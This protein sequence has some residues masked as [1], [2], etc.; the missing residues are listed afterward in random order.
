MAT[1]VIDRIFDTPTSTSTST[2][3]PDSDWKSLMN[4]LPHQ[5]KRGDEALGFDGTPIPGAHFVKRIVV[6]VKAIYKGPNPARL[7]DRTEAEAAAK[8]ETSLGE[9]GFVPKECREGIIIERIPD[10][11]RLNKK[12]PKF[13]YEFTLVAGFHRCEAHEKLTLNHGPAWAHIIADVYE[14]ITPL[15][16]D[17]HAGATNCHADYRTPARVPDIHH[18]IDESIRKGNLRHTKTDVAAFVDVVA[19]HLSKGTRTKIVQRTMK[20]RATNLGNGYQL[21]SLTTDLPQKDLITDKKS[22]HKKAIEMNLPVVYGSGTKRT[23]IN[24]LNGRKDIQTY[25]SDEAAVEKAF[26]GGVAR[27]HKEGRPKDGHVVVAFYVN[28]AELSETCSSAQALEEKRKSLWDKGLAQ[29]Q[30]HY[31]TMVGSYR[32]FLTDHHLPAMTDA[33]LYDY[34][35]RTCPVKFAGFLPQ[36]VHADPAKEGMPV[37]TTMVDWKGRPYDYLQM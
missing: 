4:A 2:V 36:V 27:W 20:L 34:V 23:T 16:R 3:T 22:A 18:Q 11:E 8:V 33:E 17:K 7:E 10:E 14:Y 9:R 24:Q 25:F 21:Q 15:A 5:P 29:F 26:T 6:A 1:T 37:E 19:A 13:G 31:E 28:T 32:D 30:S 12:S 35:K